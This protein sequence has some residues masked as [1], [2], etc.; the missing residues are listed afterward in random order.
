MYLVIFR[1]I[2]II[3]Y[4]VLQSHTFLYKNI[5]VLHIMKKDISILLLFLT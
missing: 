4:I 2:L 3:V 5:A 1:P